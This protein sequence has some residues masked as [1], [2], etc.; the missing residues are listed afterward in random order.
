[1]RYDE[2]L[3]TL[4]TA[5]GNRIYL[6]RCRVRMSQR[7]L[8]RKLGISHAAVSDI[9]RAKTRPDLDNLDTI[10]EALGVPLSALVDVSERRRAQRPEGEE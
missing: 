8:G 2:T 9:E 3:P 7:D 1:M 6:E 4:Y 10:A 5:I